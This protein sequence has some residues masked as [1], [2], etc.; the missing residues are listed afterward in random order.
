MPQ[1]IEQL[2]QQICL[3]GQRIWK[4]QFCAGNEGNHSIRLPNN[5]I[6]CTPSGLSKGFLTP[7]HILTVNLSDGSTHS[8]SAVGGLKPTSEL[9]LHLAIYK[10]HPHINAVIHAHP[11]HP[12]AFAITNTPV[13]SNIY[14]ES[15]I[16]L[17]KV[18]SV[19]Y[20]TPGSQDLA[21]AAANA[22]SPD[23]DT[24]I[25]NNHGVVTTASTL[26]KAYDKLEILD[27]YCKILLLAKPLAPPVKLSKQHCEELAQLRLKFN[28]P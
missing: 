24:A 28:T 22:I 6:L 5:K 26:I 15:D 11:P 18:P 17:G 20:F 7:A 4:R 27:S 23:S 12:A 2:K 25:L 16:F 14:P 19:P 3:I 1:N 8:P 9:N 10:K 21:N 13:P